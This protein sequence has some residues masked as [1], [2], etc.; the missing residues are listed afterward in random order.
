MYINTDLEVGVHRPPAD[1]D[2]LG[3]IIISIE[4]PDAAFQVQ[5]FVQLDGSGL[6]DAGVELVGPVE[7]GAQGDAVVRDVVQETGLYTER[8]KLD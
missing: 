1:V 7:P 5:M 6:P 8:Q 4:R 2:E 3:H